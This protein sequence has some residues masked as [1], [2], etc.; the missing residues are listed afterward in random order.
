MVACQICGRFNH[1][2]LDCY[3]RM[4][5]VYQGRHPPPQL[6]AMVA[7]HHV[8]IDSHEQLANSGANTHV[9]ADPT[10]INNPQPFAR[11]ETIGV[12]NGTGLDI[13]SIGSSVVKS[14]SS[15]PSQFLLKD[16]LYC[17][18]NDPPFTKKNK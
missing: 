14:N 8:D 9:A 18:C 11:T 6:Q 12:G 16:I 7:H 17:L 3:H 15:K 13:T 2:A 5:Y 10:T 1:T 4:D